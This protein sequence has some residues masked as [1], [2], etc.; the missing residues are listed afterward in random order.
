LQLSAS[1]I[2][3]LAN[4]PVPHRVDTK[5]WRA[6]IETVTDLGAGRAGWPAELEHARLWYEPHLD[7]IHE[8]AVVRRADLMQLE[9]IASGYPSRERFLTERDVSPRL[10][11]LSRMRSP[12]FP[13]RRQTATSGSVVCRQ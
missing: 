9:Q 7:R 5:D 13:G 11:P 2:S 12:S 8:D 1:T 6:F 4:A 3:E 10:D